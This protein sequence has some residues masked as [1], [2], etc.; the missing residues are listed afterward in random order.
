M[1]H[2]RALGW[3]LEDCGFLSAEVIRPNEVKWPNKITGT[4]IDSMKPI[5]P[6]EVRAAL[7]KAICPEARQ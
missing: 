6:E 5:K 2:A 1:C 7:K 3:P 4:R